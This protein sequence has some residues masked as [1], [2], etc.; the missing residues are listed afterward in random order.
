MAW[1]NWY[2]IW[3]ASM[4]SH[5]IKLSVIHNIWCDILLHHITTGKCVQVHKPSHKRLDGLTCCTPG[6]TR[7]MRGV[8]TSVWR[9]STAKKM[10]ATLGHVH[11]F[12]WLWKTS[13]QIPLMA[14]NHS[15][16]SRLR[17]S[18][19]CGTWSLQGTGTGIWAMRCLTVLMPD[20]FCCFIM[21]N[22]DSMSG[23][24][25]LISLISTNIV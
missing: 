9:V 10:E 18:G 19:D 4:K 3:Y 15:R 24:I 2:S 25:P 6:G 14:Q 8:K 13:H 22:Y 12:S 11:H 7:G 20:F 17:H 5:Y 21:I 1:Y 23:I 16:Y